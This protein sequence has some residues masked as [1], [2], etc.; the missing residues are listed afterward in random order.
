MLPAGQ[1]V[2]LHHYS[3]L[4]SHPTTVSSSGLC[5]TSKIWTYW[6]EPSTGQQVSPKD[7][8]HLY[9]ERLKELELFSMKRFVINM[10]KYLLNE[11]EGARLFSVMP[12]NTTGINWHKMNPM[13]FNTE[14]LFYCDCDQMLEQVDREVVESP[15]V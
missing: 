14:N 5:S 10:Y 3:P 11:E 15:S 2:I 6:S 12:G 13:K 4:L 1:E 9:E 8:H 7:D